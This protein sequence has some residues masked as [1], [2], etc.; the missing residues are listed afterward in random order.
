MKLNGKVI[1]FPLPKPDPKPEVKVY[2]C[3]C[4]SQQWF[5]TPDGRCIC[6]GCDRV[7]S[8]LVCYDVDQR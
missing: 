7:T 4:G 3:S 8:R 1:D 6:A 2:T 5:L